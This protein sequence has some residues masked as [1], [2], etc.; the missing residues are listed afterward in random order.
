MS[1]VVAGGAELRAAGGPALT[2]SCGR[3]RDEGRQD[4]GEGEGRE[5]TV[6]YEADHGHAPFG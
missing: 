5:G 4:C 1:P 2:A 3:Y 6:A